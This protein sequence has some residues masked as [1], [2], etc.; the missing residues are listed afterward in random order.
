MSCR[1]WTDEE[2]S[3]VED[4]WGIWST[5]RLAKN[6]NRTENAIV[7]FAEKNNLG[8]AYRGMY[9]STQQVADLF[10][11][12]PT[13]VARY[14]I[15]KYGLKANTQP[16]RQR[17]L[18]RILQDDLLVWCKQNQDRWKATNLPILAL[19]E[20]P[21]WL[22]EKRER[23]S[24]NK[25]KQGSTWTYKELETLKELINQGTSSSDIARTL[26][27]TYASIRSKR[28]KLLNDAKQ[29]D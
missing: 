8:G 24:L 20:E 10:S 12:D 16:L 6:L 23:D 2:R 17:R 19:G 14:W 26:G 21:D 25:S 22:I 9:L 4:K 3:L 27:R 13:T 7:R 28:Q 5:T 1:R 15:K 18:I 11:I 29:F